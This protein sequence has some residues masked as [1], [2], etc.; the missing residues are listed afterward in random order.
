MNISDLIKE[1]EHFKDV[2]GDLTVCVLG[3][4]DVAVYEGSCLMA[5]L[6]ECALFHTS[7]E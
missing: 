4:Y 2:Y 5:K 6:K 3:E 7:K 1:L